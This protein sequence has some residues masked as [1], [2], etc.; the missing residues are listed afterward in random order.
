MLKFVADPAS[1]CSLLQVKRI[2]CLGSLVGVRTEASLFVIRYKRKRIAI[3]VVDVDPEAEL[4][5]EEASGSL[6]KTV[7]S[8]LC[9]GPPGKP[10]QLDF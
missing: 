2:P 9:T 3:S 1:C 10:S 7:A 5:E 4:A 8:A 6:Q